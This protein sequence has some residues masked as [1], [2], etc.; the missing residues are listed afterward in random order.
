M[1]LQTFS[2]QDASTCFYRVEYLGLPPRSFT[3]LTLGGS[4]APSDVAAVLQSTVRIAIVPEKKV[5][6]LVFL[7]PNESW[8][9]EVLRAR[10]GASNCVNLPDGYGI[11]FR[12]P[13]FGGC[14]TYAIP[15]P[16]RPSTATAAGVDGTA[17]PVVP[18]GPSPQRLHIQLNCQHLEFAAKQLMHPR[19]LFCRFGLEGPVT[20]GGAADLFEPLGVTRSPP[21]LVSASVFLSQN[22]SG[23]LSPA[24]SL[25]A[26][27]DTSCPTGGEASPGCRSRAVG[28]A[29]DS[30]KRCVSFRAPQTASAAPALSCDSAS[31]KA[32]KRP[33]TPPEAPGCHAA[34]PAPA[35]EHNPHRKKQQKAP[36]GVSKV[37]GGSPVDQQTQPA[38]WRVPQ[39]A[40]V[41]VELSDDETPKLPRQKQQQQTEKHSAVETDQSLSGKLQT[42]RT[43]GPSG[44]SADGA[45]REG[46][47]DA[48]APDDATWHSTHSCARC[49]MPL[50]SRR[51][52]R[53]ATAA[54]TEATAGSSPCM[55]EG[56]A[57]D[58]RHPAGEDGAA[59]AGVRRRFR[60]YVRRVMEERS[61]KE[62]RRL[63]RLLEDLQL[64]FPHGPDSVAP[65]AAG[66]HSNR[67]SSS[68]A[69]PSRRRQGSNDS[70]ADQK[71]FERCLRI[72]GSA[73]AP[74]SATAEPR[75]S[76]SATSGVPKQTAASCRSATTGGPSVS[77][78][79]RLSH[80][81]EAAGGGD[82]SAA[83]SGARRA[84][85]N[86]NEKDAAP[87][88][89]C[90]TCD[91][92]SCCS[93]RV[94]FCSGAYAI[95]GDP[96]DYP[97]NPL[98][99]GEGTPEEELSP[100]EWELVTRALGILLH[101]GVI[102]L[103]AHD[104]TSPT[105]RVRLLPLPTTLP[106]EGPVQTGAAC[107]SSATREVR[108]DDEELEELRR[109]LEQRRGAPRFWGVLQ[110]P[111]GTA[112]KAEDPLVG[113][114]KA[115]RFDGGD[116]VLCDKCLSEGWVSESSLPRLLNRYRA[117]HT[118]S[119]CNAP[120]CNAQNGRCGC[121][122]AAKRRRTTA[123]KPQVFGWSRNSSFHGISASAQACNMSQNDA[124]V[125][126]SE[127]ASMQIEHLQRSVGSGY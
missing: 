123:A 60:A 101:R 24:S 28:G 92:C 38:E 75:S 58:W 3:R 100:E 23:S 45:E 20:E 27:T 97:A 63:D 107:S 113:N 81:P 127:Y 14:V 53:T 41:V 65:S 70:L 51:Y 103:V 46:A 117:D 105:P 16:T 19:Q 25:A 99:L 67:G 7:L 55:R 17:C 61:Q 95:S 44:A 112:D 118:G 30:Y 36:V 116:G 8:G 84:E 91:A 120:A 98:Y 83:H 40:L 5:R 76:S 35:E 49:R 96:P 78:A 13:S 111:R 64:P 88:D 114:G 122:G 110:A 124:E 9:V 126:Y 56:G 115:Y 108:M 2:S 121:R 21:T 18:G 74:A 72:L 11:D 89:C 80:A 31:P 48:G 12:S 68:S 29:D 119:T 57:Q 32:R 4:P 54:S 42:E 37:P 33:L 39:E 79:T 50:I 10:C 71:A 86:E 6:P 69:H 26:K 82:P 125:T 62:R 102:G 109:V 34:L 47:A 106:A 52:A 43:K 66:S 15:V 1:C 85:G 77:K 104:K 94:R 90:C 87:Y 59:T 93:K 22:P 73:T